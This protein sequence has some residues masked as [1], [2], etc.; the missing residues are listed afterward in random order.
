M[1]ATID[2][3]GPLSPND[4]AYYAPRL[5]RDA[6]P[7]RLPK[8]GDTSRPV[9]LPAT[10]ITDT[11]LDGQLEQ[12]VFDSLRHPL[13][14]EAV[15]EPPETGSGVLGMIGRVATAI[16]AAAFV[17]LLFVIVIPSLRQQAAEPSTAEVIDSMKSAIARSEQAAKSREAQPSQEFQSIAATPEAAPAVSHEESEALLRQFMQWQQKPVEEEKH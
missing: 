16:G 3:K 8:L 1:N 2:Q 5:P 9:R 15:D 17:A 14:P 11:T 7:S 12:A 4:P 13:D 10:S 6:D